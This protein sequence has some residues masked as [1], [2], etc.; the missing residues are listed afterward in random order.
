MAMSSAGEKLKLAAASLP[1]RLV[2]LVFWLLLFGIFGVTIIANLVNPM[3]WVDF[4]ITI[5]IAVAG[6]FAFI[7][8]FT[9]NPWHLAVALPVA[10]YFPVAFLI[11]PPH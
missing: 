6:V 4:A 10:I 1:T 11:W 9:K 3:S 8:F 7:F 2:A 5:Y